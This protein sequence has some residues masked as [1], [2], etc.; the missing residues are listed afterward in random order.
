MEGSS[1]NWR[2]DSITKLLGCKNDGEL[3]K[4]F[5]QYVASITPTAGEGVPRPEIKAYA[6]LKSRAACEYHNYKELGLSFCFENSILQAIHVYNGTHGFSVYK[7]DLPQRLRLNM[8]GEDIVK[9]LEE[10]DGKMGGGRGGS[11]SL[12]YKNKGL[13]I[14]FKGSDWEDRHNEIDSITIHEPLYT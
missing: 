3:I 7:G 13:Q 4:S 5:I 6:A 12:A 1:S 9:L 2:D 14:N 11:I 8:H 10:P